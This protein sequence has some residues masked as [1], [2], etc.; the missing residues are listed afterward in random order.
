M[1]TM[2]PQSQLG[3]EDSKGEF[4]QFQQFTVHGNKKHVMKWDREE[5]HVLL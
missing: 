2:T 3:D 1:T 5:K 4:Q